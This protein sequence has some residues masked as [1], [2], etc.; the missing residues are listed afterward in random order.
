MDFM[1]NN[2]NNNLQRNGIFTA[3][4]SNGDEGAERYPLP[5]GGQ[6][7][8]VDL[9]AKKAWFKTTDPRNGLPEPMRYFEINE[10]QP[11]QKENIANDMSILLEEIKSMKNDIA[12]MKQVY[13]DLK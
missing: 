6:A 12:E 8:L 13:N 10:I 9:A 7:F 1:S 5:T 2:V 11:P 4:I 3:F